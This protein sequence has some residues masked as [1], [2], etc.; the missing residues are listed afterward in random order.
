MRNGFFGCCVL[1][2]LLSADP[3]PARALH[4]PPGGLRLLFG[5]V[6]LMLVWW[7]LVYR[8]G[9]G[10]VGCAPQFPKTA[11]TGPLTF[12]VDVPSRQVCACIRPHRTVQGMRSFDPSDGHVLQGFSFALKPTNDQ[13]QML[14]RFFGAR[15]FAHNWAVTQIK[16]QL[17]VYRWL[18]VSTP[19]PSLYRLRKTWNQQKHT[20]AVNTTTGE[21]WWREVSKEVFNDGIGSA[22][23][24][25]WRWQKSRAGTHAGPRVGFPRYHSKGRRQDSFTINRQR[26]DENLVGRGCVRIPKIGWV[27]THESTRKLARLIEQ[28]RGQALAVTVTRKGPRLFANVRACVQ[29]P[30]TNTKPRTGPVRV[31]V[32]ERV[33]AVFATPDGEIVDRVENPKPMSKALARLRRLDRKLARQKKGSNRY[34]KTRMQRQKLYSRVARVRLDAVQNLTT[35][36]TKN[37]SETVIEDLCSAGMRKGGA[38]H[39]RDAMFGEFKRRMVY[40]GGWYGCNVVLADRFFPSSKTCSA[41]GT[42]GDP[43]RKQTWVCSCCGTVHDRD[44]NAAVNL[45][46]WQPHH[47][48]TVTNRRVAPVQ[49]PALRSGGTNILVGRNDVSKTGVQSAVVPPCEHNTSTLEA[50]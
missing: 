11:A 1:L 48:E 19:S 6:C 17:F 45:A 34:N 3:Q 24:A 16:A 29:R 40:K 22:V 41:C 28:G 9:A 39:L 30:Q 18:G 15:R 43:G 12:R 38:K 14:N 10:V 31:D 26:P 37:H 20:V 36:L 47:E 21:A 13:T 4:L 5:C 7:V 33:L 42:V 50:A 27:K 44:D 25:Y 32:G 8:S 23:D 35:Y 49:A 2:L 46:C